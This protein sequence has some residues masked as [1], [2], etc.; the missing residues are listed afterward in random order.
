M[1]S[2]I[3]L[4]GLI[5]FASCGNDPDDVYSKNQLVPQEEVK[6]SLN[7]SINCHLTTKDEYWLLYNDR[8]ELFA[9]FK[10]VA[11]ERDIAFTVLQF[12]FTAILF[13]VLGWIGGFLIMFGSTKL[14]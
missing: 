9:R 6:V 2:L 1:K 7:N 3:A 8:G 12:I 13:V 10:P 11:I 14:Y 5:F 4:L